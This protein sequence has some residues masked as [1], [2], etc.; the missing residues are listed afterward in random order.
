VD[1]LKE[2]QRAGVAPWDDLVWE[3]IHVAIYRDRYPV[4]PGH[5]LFVPKFK[6]TTKICDA[7]FLALKSGDEMVAE[8]KCDAYNIGIN[9]G[10]A[11]GQ[12]VMWPHVHLIPRYTGDVED[13]VGGVRN[14]IPGKGNYHC[15]NT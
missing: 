5:L 14:V 8:G 1:T 13:A 6:T 11:A 10:E 9:R 3:D 2:A 12:T 4:S 7:V 15:D